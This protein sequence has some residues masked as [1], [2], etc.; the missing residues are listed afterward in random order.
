VLGVVIANARVLPG[1]GGAIEATL[2]QEMAG[3]ERKLLGE[4]DAKA[5]VRLPAEGVDP[6]LLMEEARVLKAGE[7]FETGRKWG[8]VYHEVQSNGQS[9]LEQLQVSMWGLFNSTNALYPAVFPSVRKYEAEIVSMCVDLLHGSPL[10]AVGLLTSGGTESILLAMLAYREAARE[11]GIL[12]PEIICCRTAHPALD[13]ACHYFDIKLTKVEAGSDGRL[14]VDRVKRLI[15]ANTVAIYA[16]APTFPH[17]VVDPIEALGE[18]ALAR[19]VGLHVDNCLGGFYLSFLQ[20]IGQFK[21]KF[22]FEVPGVTSISIDIHKYAFASKGVSVVCFS[23]P[24]LRQK[25]IFPVV[26]GLALYVTPTLQGSRSGAV[27]ASAWATMLFMG[28]KG[29]RESCERLTRIYIKLQQ[30]VVRI[31]GLRLLLQP[32]LSILPMASDRYDI[33]KLATLLDRRG[34]NMFTTQDPPAMSLCI[35][36][37]HTEELADRWLEDCRACAAELIAHPDIK[38]EGEAAVYGAAKILPPEILGECLKRYIDIKM[39]VKPAS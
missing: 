19:K 7:A 12:Q 9:R 31:P 15:S 18:L 2:Q 5:N 8:G 29:Y 17:G 22:D 33:Y 28:E 4:G 3:M 35:G 24:A 1:L 26:S 36:E 37:Q 20:R 39:T 27:I 38:I 25:T 21:G 14:S 6:D 30:E 10:G 34:W 11:K 32:D 16:S 23:S 13:K